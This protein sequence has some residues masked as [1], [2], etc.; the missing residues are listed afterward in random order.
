MAVFEENMG[1]T[2][3]PSVSSSMCSEKEPLEISD[4]G[5]YGPEVLPVNKPTAPQH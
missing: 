4:T 3:F 1:L 2:G 5:F